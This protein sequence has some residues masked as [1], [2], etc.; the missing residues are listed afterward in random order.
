MSGGFSIKSKINAIKS[1]PSCSAIIVRI[2]FCSRWKKGRRGTGGIDMTH[3]LLY[4]PKCVTGM[5]SPIEKII[6]SS[7]EE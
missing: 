6:V 4:S 2:K 5:G 3:Y 1:G 7:N